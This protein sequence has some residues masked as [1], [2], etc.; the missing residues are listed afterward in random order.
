MRCS[1]RRRPARTQPQSVANLAAGE[2]ADIKVTL[3]GARAGQTA[4]FYVKAIE[5]APDLS[6]F[7]LYFTS[8]ARANATYLALGDAASRGLRGDAGEQVPDLDGRRLR[9]ARG[10]DHRRGDVRGAGLPLAA[11]PLQL[12]PLHH[13]HQARPDRRWRDDRRPRHPAG[14]AAAGQP[15][16]RRVPAPVP[17]A[18]L[19]RGHGRRPEPVLR[20]RHQR[21]R[22]RRARRDPRGLHP[23]RL[24][25]GRRDAGPRTLPAEGQGDRLRLIRPWVRTAVVRRQRRQGPLRRR[26]QQLRGLLELPGDA[27]RQPGRSRPRSSRRPR[28][29][30]PAGPRRSTSTSPVA[31]RRATRSTPTRRRHRLPRRARART[32]RRSPPATTS[33]SGTRSSPRSRA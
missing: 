7:R 32:A 24:P 4:G 9:A 21:R 23:R 5:I 31:I 10:A 30:G 26:A 8:I 3:T 6:K 11:R 29:A 17:G 25:R 20:R 27:A 22:P 13:G 15:D 28:S 1:S 14:P 18:R 12:P 16:H 19:A 33:R 2:W